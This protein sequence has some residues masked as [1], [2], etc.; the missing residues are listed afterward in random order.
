MPALL[1]ALL[2]LGSLYR[3]NN[4][5]L[6]L[7]TGLNPLIWI[8]SGRAYSEM[9]SLGLM[10]FAIYITKNTYLRSGLGLC[11]AVIKF[12]SLPF[13]VLHSGFIY[14]FQS[15]RSKKISFNNHFISILIL[16]FGFMIFLLLYLKLFNVW[17]MPSNFRDTHFNSDIFSFF[18]NFFSYGFYLAGMFFLTIP[19]F[20]NSEQIK[21]KVFLLVLST[22]LAIY[23][24]NLG[25]MDFGSFQQFLG[26]EVIL[27][28]K[29]VSFWNFLLCCQAFW[30]DEESRIMLLTILG[31]IILLSLTRPVNRYLIFVI[32]FWAI[33]ICKQ[34]CLS[35]LFWWGYISILAVLNLFATLYQVSNATASAN[36]AKWAV[37]KDVRVNL[38]G[39]VRAHVG[40][41]SHYDSNS[42]LVVSLAGNHT[43]EI[44]HEESV[45]VFGL[46]I[47][48]YVL[49]NKTPL[50]ILD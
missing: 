49:T 32:P 50:Q 31:Y 22:M 39:T 26:F 48:S 21:I 14:M 40:D 29:I 7:I 36:M 24:Q 1:G 27:L 47:R 42:N 5:W 18:T 44:L 34:I 20:I 41:F 46:P 3:I 45:M 2:L 6:L 17:I 13:I 30:K 15:F 8:Y 10:V 12:H 11:S 9:L 38:V 23:N 33:L 19:A 35:R 25:E 43:G 37:Q 28:I 4:I 16:S